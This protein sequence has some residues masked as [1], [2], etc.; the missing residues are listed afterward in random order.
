[1]SK[2]LDLQGLTT[3]YEKLKTKDLALKVDRETGKGLSQNDYTDD[4]RAAV[5]ALDAQRQ[6]G[7]TLLTPAQAE[8]LEGIAEGANL[9]TH[10][11]HTARENGLY[12]VTVDSLGHVSAA[13]AVEK[14]DLIDLGL[15][16]SDTT[17]APATGESAGLMSAQDKAKL[18]GFG[19]ADRYA[20][21]TDI[22]GLYRFRGS[23][24]TVSDLPANAE[25]GDV[26]DVKA[27]GINYA[28]TGE[29]WDALGELF[30]VDAITDS[31]IDALFQ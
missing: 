7:G 23:V 11:E 26:W 27:R 21:K 6:E 5:E 22:T 28:W 4:A 17:Y 1:M 18:D 16:E 10:P 2:Y 29:E 19:S 24:D 8:K 14:A 30:A 31:E 9:Y 15:P 20:L 3:F 25:A 12:K 13:Q